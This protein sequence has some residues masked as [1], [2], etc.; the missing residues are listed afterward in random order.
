MGW[1]GVGAGGPSPFTTTALPQSF[2]CTRPGALPP[3]IPLSFVCRGFLFKRVQCL[4]VTVWNVS[5]P[6]RSIH[7]FWFG[8]IVAKRS[9]LSMQSVL[10]L[11]PM[12]LGG[13]VKS[14]VLHPLKC[15]PVA[16]S[17]EMCA[18]QKHQLILLLF[19]SSSCKVWL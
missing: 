4:T 6:P 14:K 17:L 10:S 18:L 8:F 3:L 13:V 11:I 2:Q 15:M 9:V 5:N 12:R 19:P 1:G 16:Q 7:F